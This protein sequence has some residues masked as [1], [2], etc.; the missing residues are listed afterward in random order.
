MLHGTDDHHAPQ[1]RPL[2]GSNCFF[3]DLFRASSIFPLSSDSAKTQSALL[4]VVGYDQH[5]Y[6]EG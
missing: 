5:I 1:V 4:P 6:I 2:K 3:G